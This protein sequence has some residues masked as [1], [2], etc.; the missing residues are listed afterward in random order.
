MTSR[1][2]TVLPVR[3]GALVGAAVARVAMRSPNGWG[4]GH[5]PAWLSSVLSG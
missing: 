2:R 5:A 4:A 1:T 3:I